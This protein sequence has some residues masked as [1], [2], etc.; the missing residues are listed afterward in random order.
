[1]TSLRTSPFRSL[2]IVAALT[3]AFWSCA[4]SGPRPADVIMTGGV[5]Y[6]VSE[7]LPRATA[8]AYREGEI[9]YVGDDA[10]AERF[11][12]D[13]TEAVDLAGRMVLPGFIDTHSHPFM[14]SGMNYALTL[15]TELTTEEVLAAVVDYRDRNPDREF[16]LGFGFDE[17]AFGPEGPRADL[18]DTAV[19]D[20]PVILV[21]AG[22]HSAWVNTA[23]L[24]A[25]GIDADT[26]D[27]IPGSHYY[28][29]NPDGT[30]TGWLLESQTFFPHLAELG[31]FE[32]SSASRRSNL[33]YILY[34][35]A[36]ITTVYDA[37]MS[38][39]EDQ[40]LE[41]AKTMDDA[42]ALRFRLVA[43]LQIQHPDQVPGAIDR[44][45]MLRE[46][47]DGTLLHMGGIKIHNDGTTEARTAA[48]LEPYTDDPSNSGAVLLEP[49]VL[50]PFVVEADGAGIDVHIH[51]IGDRAVREALDALEMAR[52][53]NPGADTRHTLAHVEQVTDQDLPRFGALNVVASMTPYWASLDP[54]GNVTAVG[55]ERVTRLFRVRGILDGGGRVTSGNDFPA[56]GD[57]LNAMG[58]LW[59]IEAGA[60]R[61][62]IGDPTA[63]ALGPDSER[64]SVEEMV[65]S[66]TIDAA[67]Q[68]HMED[69]IGSIEVG[70][71]ADL[72][73]LDADLFNVPLHTIHDIGVDLTIVDG[74]VVSGRIE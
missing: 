51:A 14:A 35:T 54:A 31:A 20:R 60:T 24:D 15:N 49:A 16:I 64:M 63:P 45:A 50:N 44:F 72:V 58:P 69:R 12:G 5:V 40:A 21:D 9:V 19:S 34:S 22:G 52:N 39:F 71:R 13:E 18:L 6:T 29:R 27:P 11:R 2:V 62:A 57:E 32:S 56:T 25:F 28:Q 23:A 53:A 66:Y 7:A 65:R 1:M 43:S 48:Y 67:Y 47:Y 61:R 70:K 37:G 4:D 68:L 55:A 74:A 17:T 3:L 59:N 26:P 33:V 42:G 36:G 10:G 38:S 41:A 73:V 46:R 8:V 30:P